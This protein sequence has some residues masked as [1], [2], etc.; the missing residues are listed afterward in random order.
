MPRCWRTSAPPETCGVK[1]LGAFKAAEAGRKCRVGRHATARADHPHPG[2]RADQS[3]LLPDA[4]GA[5]DAH[6]LA[7]QE[8]RTVRAMIEAM[9]LPVV[10]R[11]MKPSREV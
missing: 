5:H 3:D 2:A 9:P 6:G 4:P 1:T 8:Q 11:V 10:Q 7:L